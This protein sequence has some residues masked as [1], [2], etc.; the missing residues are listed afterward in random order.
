MYNWLQR[1]Q[2]AVI[3]TRQRSL[4]DECLLSSLQTPASRMRNRNASLTPDPALSR[5]R[6]Q[7]CCCLNTVTRRWT[8]Y[9]TPPSP[10]NYSP[11]NVAGSTPF[12]VHHHHHYTLYFLQCPTK[13][14]FLLFCCD[15]AG[16]SLWLFWW[17]LTLTINRWWKKAHGPK[18]SGSGGP[19][20]GDW[21]WT[22][23]VRWRHSAPGS[24]RWM[25]WL[26]TTSVMFVTA[27]NIMPR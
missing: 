19:L 17:E 7:S 3:I 6:E 13:I 22:Q 4:H 11:R 12:F 15:C 10:P 2:G 24:H 25:G 27:G 18:A 5:P 8:C 21:W 26:I 16:S 23:P 14:C 9:H 1:H 20:T